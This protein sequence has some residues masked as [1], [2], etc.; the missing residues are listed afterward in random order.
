MVSD[1][2]VGLIA[3]IEA[4]MAGAV[5]Q[6]CRVHFMRNALARVPKGQA[7][8]VAAAIRTIFAQ[9]TGE[10]VREHAEV[11]AA[12]LERQFPAV[13]ELLRA[14]KADITAFADFPH[15]HW[16]KV[17]STNP[18]E[19]L[20][21]EIKRRTDVVGIFPNDQALF[22]FIDSLA[23]PCP[24]PNGGT[25]KTPEVQGLGRSTTARGPGG[26]LHAARP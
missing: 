9:P 10:D 20:N 11:V 8:M 13:A 15:A 7:E 24:G 12:T 3:A 22:A 1:A 6:R 21:K 19:R 23:K 16:R 26:G 14:A 18:L 4:T 25:P 5:W 17:W 2:H